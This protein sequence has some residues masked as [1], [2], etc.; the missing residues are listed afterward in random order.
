MNLFDVVNSAKAGGA[1]LPPE[2]LKALCE[3]L[4]YGRRQRTQKAIANALASIG[5]L[6]PD[7]SFK[8]VHLKPVAPFV[9]ITATDLRHEKQ[10]IVQGL[11]K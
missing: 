9:Y 11:L 4:S 10:L 3:V 1:G 5:K 2:Q 6:E 8:N 7:Q